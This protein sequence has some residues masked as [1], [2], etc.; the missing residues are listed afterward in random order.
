[1]LCMMTTVTDSQGYT[2]VLGYDGTI[3]GSLHRGVVASIVAAGRER[4]AGQMRLGGS[5]WVRL[6][7]AVAAIGLAIAVTLGALG[8]VGGPVPAGTLAKTNKEI[9]Y[10]LSTVEL[11]GDLGQAGI[12]VYV[13]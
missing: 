11:P 3:W 6:G 2:R 12:Q 10:D 13:P 4:K 5:G 7:R 8:G 1:M 9:S